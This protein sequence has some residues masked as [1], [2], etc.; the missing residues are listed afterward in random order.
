MVKQKNGNLVMPDAFLELATQPT[1]EAVQVGDD[2]L[3]VSAPLDQRRLERIR[4]LAD[5]SIKD[6]RA[7]LERLGR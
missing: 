7:S 1:Y 3:L 5:A 6:H 2:V 4:S